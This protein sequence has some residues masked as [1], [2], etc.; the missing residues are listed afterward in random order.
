MQDSAPRNAV[1]WQDALT[2]SDLIAVDPAGLGGAVLRACA[3]P[4]RDAWLKRLRGGLPQSAPV[5]RAPCDAGDAELL[6]G[7]DL[8]ATLST[9]HTVA[10]RGLLARSHG[11]LLVLP[12]A[13]RLGRTQAAHISAALDAGEVVAERDGLTIRSPARLAAIALDEGLADDDRP[14]AALL[15]RLAFHVDL[16]EMSH[17]DLGD[18]AASDIA[19][20]RGRLSAVTIPDHLV[21]ALCAACAALGVGSAR[22]PLLALKAAKASAAL[23]GRACVADQDAA[24]AARLV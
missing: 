6:G 8:S 3:G 20:A 2:A 9:G 17:R 4:V 11:G 16:R 13:E 10:Q 5:L 15:E 21:E 19:A 7:L 14:P 12:M 18:E 24:L 1:V 23:A 22:A